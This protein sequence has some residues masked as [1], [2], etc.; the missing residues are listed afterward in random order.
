M[1]FKKPL[2]E[3][4]PLRKAVTNAYHMD[5]TEAVQALLKQ[6]SLS[7]AAQDRIA[8]VATDLVEKVRRQ[9]LGKGGLDAF[10][11]QYDLSSEEGIALMCLAE[12]LLRVPDKE[13]IDKLI[14]DKLSAA[15]WEEHAGKSESMFVN[16]ATWGL[17]LTGKVFTW[18]ELHSKT[19]GSALKKIAGRSGEPVLR[20]SVSYA[21]KV[22][23]RQF[24]MGRTINEA[25]T[26]AKELE[27]KGYSYSYDMLGEAARTA[28]D[29]EVYFK[30]YIEAIE[31]IGQQAKG[32]RPEHNPGVSVKLS[33][34]HPRYEF[35]QY[36]KAVPAIS[37]K[38][39]TLAQLAK[40]HNIN[41]TIDAEEAH[42]LDLSLDIIEQVFSDA[43]LDGWQGFGL[44][45]QSYQKRAPAVIDWLVDLARRYERRI[46]VRLIKGAYWDT[47]IKLSQENGYDGY[48]VFT[49]K[50][51]TDVSFIA[52]AKK[53]LDAGEVFFPQ[54]A[55][56]NANS[57]ATV[58]ELAG[59]RR[60]FEFQCLH[61]MGQSLYDS[62]VGEG[63][64][65]IPCRI[66]APVGSHE[67][68]LGYLVRRLLENG[69]NTSF[70]NRI[71]DEKLPIEDIIADPVVKTAKLTHIPHP[72]IPLP[73]ALYGDLRRNSRGLDLTN[74]AL[75]EELHDKLE[76]ACKNQWQ[77]GPVINGQLQTETMRPAHDSSNHSRTIGQVS[78]ADSKLLKRAIDS[79]FAAQVA[80]N[81]TPVVE[82][83]ACLEKAAD[84]LEARSAEFMAVAI[85]EAGKTVADAVAEIR[86]AVDFCRYY[87][88]I[89]KQEMTQAKVM[90]GPTGEFNQL[91]LH[92]RGVIACISPWN[93]PLAIF[94]GQVVAALVTGNTVV[95]K[96]AEQTP[97]IATMA[98]QLLLE[99]G[100]P[101]EA[102]QLVPGPG[103]TIGAGLVND[104]RIAGVMFTG[105]TQ[106]ARLI[107]QSL[108]AREGPIVPF[109]A[110]TG[111][112][113]CMIMD[114]TALPEQAV[115]DVIQSAFGSAGQRCSALRVLFVQDDVAD[116]FITMLKGAMAELTVGDPSF[117]ATDVGP[118]ID[119][120]ALTMLKT[121][122][123]AMAQ[124]GILLAEAPLNGT[125]NGNYFAPVVFEIKTLAQLPREVFGPILHV[126]R[127]QAQDLDNVIEAIN[128]TGYGLTLGIHSRID[129]TVDYI[130]ARVKV[131]NAYVNRTMI[132]AVVGV[133]PFGGEGLSGTG[134]KAGGPH[135]L[136]RL[137][138]ERTL[139]VDTTA[140]GGNA[141]LMSL[142]D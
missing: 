17:M 100:V 8:A 12:A 119:K 59:R 15:D 90:P 116:G 93:F 114:S 141:S 101:G 35:A 26:R 21:M 137:C 76:Q 97:I 44:A 125:V 73:E 11:T 1:I 103:E 53:I 107:N 118:V 112:Q 58:L 88:A 55:T 63:D 37:A 51:S 57:V 64:Y 80:W 34:L 123:D 42:C 65:N 94:M 130:Q 14:K 126:I 108:A 19:L 40:R 54:F 39:L 27:D 104:S 82:R 131:G 134:P 45:V 43:S 129:E 98:V 56:H 23:G 18:N 106:T 2:N 83:A 111:G 105:S 72:S 22:L 3:Q 74:I 61:G 120:D 113:N 84:L 5:E 91:T 121:H 25:L 115:L 75:L 110:E 52:C 33:A 68:L 70:V 81:Q 36:H 48:P 13:T 117:L 133:Q 124:E 7:K 78:D 10:L 67:D 71:V 142:G 92:G 28:E 4:S 86:E 30:A 38:V 16:A 50:S 99:A 69:A 96:P 47:E 32:D 29:A 20:K 127:Y 77:G 95:A 31:A 62:V 102:L 24:V 109:I 85:R 46:M 135:Y 66:Y 79:A 132:G 140:A 138:T 60:D 139:S 9:R 136:F 41:L 49:R 89:A 122:R 6:A 128:N 87:A